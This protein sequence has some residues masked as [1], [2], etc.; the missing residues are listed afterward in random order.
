MARGAPA[1]SH[2]CRLRRGSRPLRIVRAAIAFV[3]IVVVRAQAQPATDF[4]LKDLSGRAW[5]LSGSSSGNVVLLDFWATW[6]V[7]CIKELPHLQ[8]LQNVYGEKGLQV[9]TISIDGPDRVAAVSALVARYGFS[10]PVLLDTESRVISIYNPSLILPHAVL[11][12]RNG[13]IRYVHQGYSPGDE[14]LLEEKIVALLGE[15]APKTK[16]GTSVRVN[17]SFLL[18]LPKEGSGRTYPQAG[19]T[20][21]I[22]QLDVTVS[23]RRLLAGARLDANLDLSPVEPE[24]RLQKRYIQYMAGG[25][26]ARAGDFYTSLGRGLVFSLLKVFEEEGVDYVVDTTVDGGQVSFATGAFSSDVFGGWIDRPGDRSVHDKVVGVGVGSTWGGVGTVRVQGV[27]A[28]IEPGGEFKNHRVETG[29]ISVELPELGGRAAV[30]GE[31]SLMRRRTYPTE[32]PIGGHGLYVGSKL[33]A[34]KYSFLFE[35]KDY[36]ELN[37]EFGRPP[38]L[39]SEDLDIVADQFDLDRTDV[40]GVSARIDH[41]SPASQTLMYAKYLRIHDDPEAHRVYGRYERDIGHVLA[42]IEKKFAGGGYLHGLAGW[43]N[44]D[45]TPDFFPTEGGTI[46]DQVNVSWPLRSGWSVEGDW[47]HKV[48]NGDSYNYS[49]IRTALSVH[50]SPRWVLSALYERTTDPAILFVSGKK[51]YRAGQLEVRLPRGHSLRAFVGST[52]GSVKCAGGVCR[53]FPAFEGVRVEAFV[54]F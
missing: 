17:D 48:F 33:N 6:C 13:I 26:Q 52:K 51:D 41:Y 24:L 43:R 18:R 45:A 11:V 32:A 47:K 23:N 8:R 10:V 14:R 29:S 9:L 37:F 44:E 40:S 39:E 15:S 50:R 36:K 20:E 38:L 54:R 5:N 42:G 1:W 22:D 3:L 16:R 28:E 35:I 49:E 53:L 12:D 27:S 31:F 46:H 2:T 7:P 4:T 25:F 21:C 19:Y 34:G 30:Y